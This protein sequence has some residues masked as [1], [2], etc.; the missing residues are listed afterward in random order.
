MKMK[1]VEDDTRLLTFYQNSAYFHCTLNQ[2]ETPCA[3]P[4][5]PPANEALLTMSESGFPTEPLALWEF[6]KGMDAVFFPSLMQVQK[7]S[8]RKE[9]PW[10]KAT[11]FS[12]LQ[13]T[14]LLTSGN[15]M[16]AGHKGRKA[17]LRDDPSSPSPCKEWKCQDTAFEDDFA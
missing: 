12:G 3:R 5:Y 15:C 7:K 8:C 10:R 4:I 9:G 2:T 13:L 11:E 16:P 1:I 14:D 17:W 6:E